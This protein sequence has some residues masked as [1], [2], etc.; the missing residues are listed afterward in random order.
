MAGVAVL[1]DDVVGGF[2]G[3][4]GG[5]G[6]HGH[7]GALLALHADLANG[8]QALGDVV[9]G[10]CLGSQGPEGQCGCWCGQHLVDFEVHAYTLMVANRARGHGF[11]GSV[12]YSDKA[13][14]PGTTLL[15]SWVLP[16]RA[17]HGS[18]NIECSA[19]IDGQKFA[20]VAALI[21]RAGSS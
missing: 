14:R 19:V 2:C 4:A 9:G 5:H 3:A 12:Q 17:G 18:L 11:A 13:C 7:A 1:G 6:G 21:S 16:W 15:F 10:G 8:L 20:G